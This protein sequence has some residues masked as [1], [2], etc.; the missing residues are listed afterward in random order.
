MKY[1]LAPLAGFTPTYYPDPGTAAEETETINMDWDEPS[2]PDYIDTESE[3]LLVYNCPS[4]GAQLFADITTGATSC[5]YCGNTT[6][7]PQQFSGAL[8]PEYIIPFKVTK[9]QAWAN[10]KNYVKETY[11]SINVD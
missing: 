11:P 5:V 3:G 8:R 6:I 1:I 4:C 2:D 7:I 10:F 9:D